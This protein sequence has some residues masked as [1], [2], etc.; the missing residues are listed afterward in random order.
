MH[1]APK[2]VGF[3]LVVQRY[4]RFYLHI[5]LHVTDK[6]LHK[7]PGG[8]SEQVHRYVHAVAL[9][10]GIAS[11]SQGKVNSDESHRVHALTENPRL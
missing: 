3:A 4:D 9:A 1:Q 6:T 11:H 10:E 8:V 2:H 7:Y 5:N